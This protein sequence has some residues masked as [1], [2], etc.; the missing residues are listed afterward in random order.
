MKPLYCLYSF[1][2]LALGP[3]SVSAQTTITFQG[4]EGSPSDTWNFTQPIQNM[5]PPIVPVGD[6]NYGPGYALTGSNSMRVGGGGTACGN[7]S[8]NCLNGSATGGGCSDNLNGA[9]VEFAPVNISCYSNVK[10]SVAHRTHTPCGGG[11]VGLDTGEQLFFE[12]SSNGGPWTVAASVI[13]FGDCTWGYTT[14]PVSCNGNPPVANPYVYNVPAG[15]QTLAFRVRIQR[16]RSDEVFYLDDL[17]L[18]GDPVP[19]API[20]I[21][22]IDP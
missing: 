14:N 21:Q 22:H 10:L 5:T 20:S 7:G 3:V 12:T 11:G 1:F 16:N 6:N 2:A 8:A 15:T 18:T 17:K 9:S 19:L 13:G 4:F